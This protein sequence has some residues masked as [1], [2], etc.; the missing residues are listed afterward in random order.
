MDSPWCFFCFLLFL[1]GHF[2]DTFGGMWKIESPQSHVPHWFN[3]CYTSDTIALQRQTF[4]PSRLEMS[5]WPHLGTE[6]TRIW[7]SNHI[8]RQTV[9]EVGEKRPMNCTVSSCQLEAQGIS[10]TSHQSVNT[11][12]LSERESSRTL[13]IKTVECKLGERTE[14]VRFL[15]KNERT[16]DCLFYFLPLNH[17]A[18]RNETWRAHTVKSDGVLSVKFKNTS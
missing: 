14:N 1:L 9:W 15:K 12:N 10:F 6:R 3:L 7:L 5:A 16:P 18:V 11:I 13:G 2:G 17:T 4:Q 8:D